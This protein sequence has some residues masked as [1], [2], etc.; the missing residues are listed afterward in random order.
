MDPLVEAAIK[1]ADASYNISVISIVTAFITGMFS[2]LNMLSRSRIEKDTEKLKSDLT[3]KIETLKSD[4]ARQSKRLEIS[5]S[6]LY[7]ERARRVDDLYSLYHEMS[8]QLWH[9]SHSLKGQQQLDG[10]EKAIQ[11]IEK[12]RDYLNENRIYFPEPICVIIDKQVE[13]LLAGVGIIDYQK[14]N[15]NF[16]QDWQVKMDKRRNEFEVMRRTLE[17]HF[18]ELLLA[19]GEEQGKGN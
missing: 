5:F 18:R 14:I 6:H 1:T 2:V 19:S 17:N 11:P 3:G 16:V 12:V 9:W 7:K 10:F 13:E 8:C 15:V 4:L